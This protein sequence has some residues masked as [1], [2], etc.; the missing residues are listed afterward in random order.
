MEQRTTTDKIKHFILIRDKSKLMLILQNHKL[1]IQESNTI[2]AEHLSK[3]FHD[4]TTYHV[5][6]YWNCMT[7]VFN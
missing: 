1:F 2:F 5:I 7:S 4:K 6:F 3:Y